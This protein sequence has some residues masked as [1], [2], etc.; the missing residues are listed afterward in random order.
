[1]ADNTIVQQRKE[2][3]E[4]LRAVDETARRQREILRRQ[5]TDLDKQLADLR[6]MRDQTQSDLSKLG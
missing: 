6:R 3:Q 2:A 5:L 4:H 1:M